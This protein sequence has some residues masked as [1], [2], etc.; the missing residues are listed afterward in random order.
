MRQHTLQ[1]L[2]LPLTMSSL[3]RSTL[4]TLNIPFVK[5]VKRSGHSSETKQFLVK[6][7][8][9]KYIGRYNNVAN[10]QKINPQCCL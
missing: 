7:N 2:L 5:Q 3:S 1:L 6:Q 9:M 4:L 10:Q 8:L